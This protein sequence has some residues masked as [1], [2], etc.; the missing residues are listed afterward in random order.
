MPRYTPPPINMAP[1]QPGPLSQLKNMALNKGLQHGVGMAFGDPT[2]MTGQFAKDA[3]TQILPG[4]L[5][6]NEGGIAIDPANKGKFTAKANAAGEGVQEY[7]RKVLSAP[8]GQYDPATRKQANFARNAAKWH[9]EGGDVDN[10]TETLEERVKR[11]KKKSGRSGA[12]ISNAIDTLGS[13]AGW[14]NNG[15]RID[16]DSFGAPAVYR[17]MGGPLGGGQTKEGLME[18]RRLGALTQEE[19]LKAM[20]HAGYLNEGG[21]VWDYIWGKGR[22]GEAAKSAMDAKRAE[23]RANNAKIAER[24]RRASPYKNDGGR[25]EADTFGAPDNFH[26]MPDGRLMAG[27]T[28]KAGVAEYKEAGGEVGPLAKTTVKDKDGNMTE[29]MYHNPLAAKPEK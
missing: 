18:A 7:A 10:S 23:H 21:T 3:A 6:L 13:K 27:A 2:G 22:E 19:F 9:N 8:E 5:G 26:Y 4:V 16:A 28:H 12:W 11:R 25:A 1:A 20:A 17:E 15:G 24:M 29:R 14:W